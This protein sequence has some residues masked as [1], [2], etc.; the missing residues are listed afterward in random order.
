[1]LLYFIIFKDVYDK[2]FINDVYR[3]PIITYL[4]L[5][6]GQ[7]TNNG[8][9][10]ITYRTRDEYKLITKKLGLMDDFKVGCFLKI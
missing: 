8:V 7:V 5:R 4:D 3:N 2:E 9:F 10:R 1:M 6:E